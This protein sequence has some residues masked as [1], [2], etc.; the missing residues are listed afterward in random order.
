METVPD[1][2]VGIVRTAFV[3]RLV[4]VTAAPEINA[5]DGSFTV[6]RI[7]DVPVC[8]QPVA[9]KNSAHTNAAKFTMMNDRFIDCSFRV[10]SLGIKTHAGRPDGHR[11]PRRSARAQSQRRIGNFPRATF[12]HSV[13]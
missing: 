5:L 11:K 13:S 7:V 9:A 8:A 3:S 4:S 12:H 1:V 6:P 2:V 10:P